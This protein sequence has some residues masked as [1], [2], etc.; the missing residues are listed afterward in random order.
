MAPPVVGPDGALSAL[1]EPSIGLLPAL[2]CGEFALL[3][4]AVLC[5]HWTCVCPF[6]LVVCG[7]FEVVGCVVVFP[8]V[9]CAR[10]GAATPSIPIMVAAAMLRAM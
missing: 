10:A 6:V 8:C 4:C 2:D 1:P 5:K 7:C 9:D 3:G